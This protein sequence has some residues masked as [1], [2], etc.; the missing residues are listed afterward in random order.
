MR[1]TFFIGNRVSLGKIR[2]TTFAAKWDGSF[3]SPLKPMLG[4]IGKPE[5][6]FSIVR[7]MAIGRRS[8]AYS[9]S[10]YWKQW[11][12]SWSYNY[13][14]CPVERIHLVSL[15]NL[16]FLR[17]SDEHGNR[18][19]LPCPVERIHLVSLRN[20]SFLRES[21]EHGNRNSLLPS[22][23]VRLLLSSV[24]FLFIWDLLSSVHSLLSE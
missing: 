10:W 21:D 2:V 20:L 24:H 19:S 13:W 12:G 18:N 5:S 17:E 16:S 22:M 4:A 8:Q 3:D 11:S 1:Y 23:R 7:S 6:R 9:H 14:S 15:R